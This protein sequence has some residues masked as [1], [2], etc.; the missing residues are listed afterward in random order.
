MNRAHIEMEMEKDSLPPKKSRSQLVFALSSVDQARFFPGLDLRTGL[1]A[2]GQWIDVAGLDPV[3][4]EKLLLELNPEILVT[5]WD[6][7]PLPEAWVGRPDLS[8]RYV[9]HLTGGLAGQIPR[10]L[11]EN[12]VLVSNWGI[13]IS[14]TIAEQAVLLT[15][16]A[17]RSLPLW[18]TMMTLPADRI[19]RLRTRSLRGNR[20]GL[21]GFGGIAREIA[22][23][24]TPFQVE[25]SAYSSGAPHELFSDLGVHRCDSLEELFSGSDILIECEVLTARTR[26]SVTADLLA[27]LPEDAVFVNVGRGAVVD[28]KA[29]IALAQAGRI[30]VG[31]DVF[32]AEPL[33]ADSPFF[34]IPNALL[35]PHVAGPTWDEFRTCGA[36]ALANVERYLRGEPVEGKVTLEIYDRIN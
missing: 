12:G 1:A 31:L 29:L 36:F 22:R 20:V 34:E 18:G 19:A 13:A 15:L 21:H 6:T 9:C 4:W 24:L 11:L 2:E 17:L 26:G 10:T 25:I 23:L 35:S 28:E 32:T 16:G 27:L 5:A 7:P 3:S 8:L 30:R 33:P 14:H